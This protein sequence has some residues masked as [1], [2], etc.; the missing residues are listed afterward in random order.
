MKRVTRKPSK[1]VKDER[2]LQ[3]EYAIDYGIN[4]KERIILLTGEVNDQMFM[5]V[6][7]ALSLLEAESRKTITIRLSSAGGTVYDALAI[8]GRITQSSCNIAIEGYGCVMSAATLILAC[9]DVRRISKYSWFM[10]HEAQYDPGHDKHSN[11]KALIIQYEREEKEWAKHM[12][13]FTTKDIEFW[14]KAGQQVDAYFTAQ[15]LVS[16]G[17]ADEVI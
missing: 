8:V 15:D 14:H 1:N 5:Q 12:A 7:T 17:V 16:M 11:H 13:S 6:E 4:L 9:G 10:T 3:L 2:E